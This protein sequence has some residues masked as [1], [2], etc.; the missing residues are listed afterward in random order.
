MTI[1]D[2][3]DVYTMFAL[4]AED[5]SYDSSW[6]PDLPKDND[7]ICLMAAAVGL[8]G[9]MDEIHSNDDLREAV[10]HTMSLVHSGVLTTMQWAEESQRI[11]R[12][13]EERWAAQDVELRR[14]R[15]GN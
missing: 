1:E 8:S 6:W 2:V 15:E 12:E 10:E 14:I 7:G 13:V 3:L 9:R 4:S 5:R 11:E